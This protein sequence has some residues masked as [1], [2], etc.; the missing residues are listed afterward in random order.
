MTPATPVA[1]VDTPAVL[2]P[3]Y[4]LRYMRADDIPQVVE[5]DTQSFPSPWSARSYAFEVNDNMTSHM[6][7]LEMLADPAPRPGALRAVWQ[8]IS[9][10]APQSAIVGYTGLWLIAGE[11]HIST[12][13]VAPTW[14]GSRLGE[15]LLNGTLQRAIV[16]GGDYSVLEVR[17]SNE[18]AQ[19]LY[20]KYGYEVVQRKKHYYRDN[21]EDA[22]MMHIGPLD[23]AYQ[24]RLTELAGQLH[25]R[26]DYVDRLVETDKRRT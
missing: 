8:R 14:R 21:D 4:V 23:A 20:R 1:A 12:I 25:E 19:S 7:V 18:P 9:G 15:L 17:V 22:F 11:A 3:H 10:H 24:A 2:R 5:V 6:I 16:L 26:I 13:A